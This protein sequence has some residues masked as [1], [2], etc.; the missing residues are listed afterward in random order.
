MT[1][2]DSKFISN[3]FG[4]VNNA[5]VCFINSI[6]Q[7]LFS[8]PYFNQII[9]K[10]LDDENRKNTLKRILHIMGTHILYKR[11]INITY[12]TTQII[13]SILNINANHQNDMME[14]FQ[15]FLESINDKNIDILYKNTYDCF[16][17]CNSC[18]FSKKIV[19]EENMFIQLNEIEI[20]E[21]SVLEKIEM[22]D[23]VK[24]DKCKK[25]NIFKKIILSHLPANMIFMHNMNIQHKLKTRLSFYL[26]SGIYNYILVSIV[27][28]YGR[29]NSGHYRTQNYRKKGLFL[30]DDNYIKK[31]ESYDSNNIYST[32]Y[33]LDSIT[34]Y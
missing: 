15:K 30:I 20:T 27:Q 13:C 5:N 6:I 23:G 19:D 32:Q 31:I 26:S 29:N 9:V 22:I 8:S 12:K 3:E 28:F 17:E 34:P 7:Y 1:V 18:G 14:F 21:K 4:I 10:E 2:L 33:I 24:C 25:E 11:G 16:L